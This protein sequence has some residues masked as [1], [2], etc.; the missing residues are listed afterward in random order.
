LPDGSANGPDHVP[1]EDCLFRRVKRKLVTDDGVDAIAFEDNGPGV[2]A[3]W[4][5]HADP[6]HCRVGVD[7][8][9][10][11]AVVRLPVGP[12][13]AVPMKVEHTPHRPNGDYR[14][15]HVD[16]IGEK[17]IET[18]TLLADLAHVVVPAEPPMVSDSE[19]LRQKR[20]A[21]AAEKLSSKKS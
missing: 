12:V 3:S 18:R 17:T 5:R 16:I 20:A 2:S 13:R 19:L 10:R 14:R 21:R 8:P 6:E 11:F 7:Q 1:D 15:E 9:H 4:C